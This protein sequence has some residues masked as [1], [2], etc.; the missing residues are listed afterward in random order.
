MKSAM[1]SPAQGLPKV[2]R[3]QNE[4]GFFSSE[5]VLNILKLIL[6]G[7]E[8]SDVLTIIAQLVESQGIGTLCT[9]WLPDADGKRLHCAGPIKLTNFLD[10]PSTAS[11]EKSAE[12]GSSTPKRCLQN[13]TVLKRE[14]NRRGL[15]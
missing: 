13:V 5:S 4:S 11:G 1:Q 14:R 7:S 2:E 12:A 6:A 9:I 10:K 3:A 15:Q 8:L